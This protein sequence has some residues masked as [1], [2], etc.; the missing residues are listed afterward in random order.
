M[1][2]GQAVVLKERGTLSY[3]QT[4][5]LQEEMS[6]KASAL[7]EM[8]A[9]HEELKGRSQYIAEKLNRLEVRPRRPG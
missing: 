6:S 2:D 3:V 1:S 8:H 4:R 9:S 7:H 5:V